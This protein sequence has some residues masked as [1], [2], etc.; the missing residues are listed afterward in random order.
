[1]GTPSRARAQLHGRSAPLAS[2]GSHQVMQRDAR[3][4]MLEKLVFVSAYNL[5]GAVHG[6]IPVG[7]VAQKH[8]D[9]VRLV[10]VR[11]RRSLSL[12]REGEVG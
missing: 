6:G 12:V 11:G 7:E 8:G 3:R 2:L 1:M 4:V 9:E 5:V 10:L